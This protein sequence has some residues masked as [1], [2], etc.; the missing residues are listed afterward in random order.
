MDY[1]T[2]QLRGSND[3]LFLV[4]IHKYGKSCGLYRQYSDLHQNSRGTLWYCQSSAGNLREKQT[5]FI[6]QKVLIPSDKN[7]LSRYYNL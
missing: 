3:E 7:W 5:D 4:R 1:V 2:S 6:V